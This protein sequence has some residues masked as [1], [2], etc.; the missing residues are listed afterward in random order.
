MKWSQVKKRVEESL[1]ESVRGRV[2]FWMTRYRHA[3]DH[4][5]EGWITIDKVRVASMGTQTF[6]NEYYGTAHK[7]RVERDCLDYRDPEQQEEYYK[8]YQEADTLMVERGIFSQGDF[9]N[10]LF[11]FLNLSIDQALFSD[12]PITRGLAVLDHRFGK[13]RIAQFDI[14]NEHPLVAMLYEFRRSAEGVAPLPNHSMQPT[15]PLR[16][17]AADIDR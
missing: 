7:L 8:A 5:G 9:S 12:S 4:V 15:V 11:E 16:G 1:A 3:H 13:R 6:F 14:S 17:P 10:A 2:E